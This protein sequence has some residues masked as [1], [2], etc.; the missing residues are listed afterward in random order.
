MYFFIL[1][2]INFNKIGELLTESTNQFGFTNLCL[3]HEAKVA[4]EARSSTNLN[5][6]LFS[7]LK[8]VISAIILLQKQLKYMKFQ[9]NI[10]DY[11][12]IIQ[13]NIGLIFPVIQINSAEK[14]NIYIY[15]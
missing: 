11:N 4:F 1:F 7:L 10:N 13:I 15:F 2:K 12:V 9:I 3:L 14:R 5:P 6:F 8:Y